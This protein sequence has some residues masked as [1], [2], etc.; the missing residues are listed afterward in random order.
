MGEIGCAEYGT[1]AAR[2]FTVAIGIGEGSPHR[3]AEDD[4]L[5]GDAVRRSCESGL[6]SSGN[7]RRTRSGWRQR[8]KMVA[9]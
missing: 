5:A 7:A 3:S 9:N 6:S 1:G 4:G 2:E 8:R